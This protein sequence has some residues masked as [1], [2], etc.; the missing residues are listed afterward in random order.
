MSI[1]R[2]DIGI[3]LG[4]VNVVVYV[5]G[6]GIVIQEPSV[7]AILTREET[8]VEVGEE[9][10]QMYG[11]TPD[12]IEVAR[13][14]RDGVIA[15][16]QVTQKMLEH[17]VSKAQGLHLLAAPSGDWR[18][19]WRDQRGTPRR[20][21]SGAGSRRRRSSICCR[22]AGRGLRRRPARRHRHR[23]PGGRYGRRHGRGGRGAR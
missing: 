16:Y 8:V 9:A 19:V 21:R 23:Q 5:R 7:V 22:T 20:A 6:K 18:A 1:F 2:A 14:V 17:F 12:E 4:T 11:R 15:D 3:D 13:P 10:R